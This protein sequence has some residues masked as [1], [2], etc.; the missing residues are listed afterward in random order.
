MT[1]GLWAAQPRRISRAN[2]TLLDEIYRYARQHGARL[3]NVSTGAELVYGHCNH[4]TG[5]ISIDYRLLIVSVYVHEAI[6][7]LHPTWS[8]TT[9]RRRTTQ[10][11]RSM[12]D[13]QIRALSLAILDDA[14]LDLDLD[15]LRPR[16]H[17]S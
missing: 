4:T 6:H 2:A 11:I 7:A 12:T 14:A 15:C 3:E 9:T 13:A 16:R 5:Q 1:P 8:E 17:A 10:V